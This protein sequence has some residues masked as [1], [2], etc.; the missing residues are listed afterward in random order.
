M[1]SCV[2]CRQQKD[3]IRRRYGLDAR[4]Q[5]QLDAYLCNYCAEELSHFGPY[6]KVLKRNEL[7]FGYVSRVKAPMP[8]A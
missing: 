5:V 7:N 6:A 3:D 2:Y 8:A 1:K 4:G